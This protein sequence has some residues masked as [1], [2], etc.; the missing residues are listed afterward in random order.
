MGA[1]EVDACRQQEKDSTIRGKKKGKRNAQQVTMMMRNKV[2]EKE[3]GRKGKGRWN[4]PAEGAVGGMS[5]TVH[6]GVEHDTR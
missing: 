5:W 4:R 1:G 3:R 6:G 2:T